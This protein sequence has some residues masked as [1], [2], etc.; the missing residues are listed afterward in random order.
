VVARSRMTASA[1]GER[2][3]LP[4]QTAVMRNGV[5]RGDGEDTVVMLCRR[6]GN[7]HPQAGEEKS[8]SHPSL[9]GE[10]HMVI[11]RLSPR[12]PQPLDGCPQEMHRV[13][14]SARGHTSVASVPSRCCGPH[15]HR[16]G[17][18]KG[19]ITA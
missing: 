1:I 3:I 5:D 18:H 6:E 9:F 13:V 16:S 7:I 4:K 14:D 2:Q 12:C 15:C 17:V 19:A 8:R 10:I 11:P